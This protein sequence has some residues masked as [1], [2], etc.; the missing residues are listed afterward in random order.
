MTN[1]KAVTKEKDPNTICP[2]VLTTNSC[3]YEASTTINS[4][5]YYQRLH[6]P[7]IARQERNASTTIFK[8]P[9]KSLKKNKE[10]RKE[11]GGKEE[12]AGRKGRSHNGG[13]NIDLFKLFNI[14]LTN[15]N[16]TC[17]TFVLC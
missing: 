15:G 9:C 5:Q 11:R 17:L 10:D 2:P 7:S 8:T 13:K 4:V 14:C 1:A 6:A 16:A 3:R 12:K